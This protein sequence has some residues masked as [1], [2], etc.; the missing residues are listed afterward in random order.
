MDAIGATTGREELSRMTLHEI[1]R[2]RPGARAVL[3]E[4]GLDLCCGG[5]LPLEEAASRHGLELEALLAEI[6]DAAGRGG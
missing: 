3:L 4:H 6:R 1:V 5:E 2:R